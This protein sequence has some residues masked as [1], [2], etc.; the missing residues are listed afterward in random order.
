MLRLYAV[1][2]QVYAAM[3]QVYAAML[4]LYAVIL[5]VY[6]AMLRLYAA[7]LRL[8]AAILR[9]HA[10]MHC[11]LAAAHECALPDDRGYCPDIVRREVTRRLRSVTK[12]YWQRD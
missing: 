11:P 1:I 8:Y 12:E 4:R 9:L 6:A 3:L 2:L 7:I 10:S 5:Q